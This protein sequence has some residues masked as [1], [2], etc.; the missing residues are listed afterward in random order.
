MTY[1]ESFRFFCKCIKK[2]W[3]QKLYFLRCPID[4]ILFP[5]IL[6]FRI[7]RYLLLA[8]FGFVVIKKFIQFSGARVLVSFNSSLLSE[9]TSELMLF[10][11][12]NFSTL[13]CL[14]MRKKGYM[15]LFVNILARFLE[16]VLT[17]LWYMSADTSPFGLFR[18]TALHFAKSRYFLASFGF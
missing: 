8:S 12:I 13:L 15:C 10:D 9:I 3:G 5:L 14:K 6:S 4:T 1:F 18:K 2:F 7:L 11:F 16:F 17:W